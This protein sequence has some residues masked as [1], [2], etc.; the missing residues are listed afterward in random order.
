MSRLTIV[1]IFLIV[2]IAA[3]PVLAQTTAFTYQGKL[4][5]NGISPTGGY[6]MRFQLYDAVTGGN[7]VGGVQDLPGVLVASG[8]FTVQLDFGASVF[9]SGADL[10]LEIAVRQSGN[11]DLHT[12][13]SP[14][15]PI[16]S[17]PF[18]IRSLMSANA[19]LL[20][21]QD[22][23]YYLNADNIISGTLDDSRLSSNI[24]RLDQPNQ[25]FSGNTTIGNLTLASGGQLFGARFENSTTDPALTGLS[26]ASS[27][28]Q[29]YYNTDE[30]NL[31]VF[32]GTNWNS[33]VSRR[34]TTHSGSALVNIPCN[35]VAQTADVHSVSFN[36][37]SSTSRL[38]INYSDVAFVRLN[39]T[40]TNTSPWVEVKIDGTSIAPTPI[41]M[42]F[43]L[44]QDEYA[45]AGPPEFSKQFT[46]FGYAENIAAGPHTL[47]VRY[48]FENLGSGTGRTCYR[49]YP[50]FSGR[51]DPFTIEIEEVP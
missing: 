44:F 33:I 23:L 29:T 28:G 10:W 17:S 34:V 30:K 3:C 9:N 36:K 35:N 8:I 40:E 20:G 11:P 1:E 25:T 12:V 22:P 21:G 32:D 15:Q 49:G 43:L 4:A 39:T 37:A 41:R 19:D 24:A 42:Q 13:L 38:R 50:F 26:P 18:S 45:G 14:R 27:E 51:V 47:T 5:D 46:I 31:K 6:D 7:A 48:F 16:S 2:L